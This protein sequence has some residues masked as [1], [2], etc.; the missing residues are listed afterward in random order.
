MIWQIAATITILS[1]LIGAGVQM[2]EMPYPFNTPWKTTV[3]GLSA[4]VFWI[5]FPTTLISLI[6]SMF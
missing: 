6:W 4:I 1:W 3:A 5:A 2:N